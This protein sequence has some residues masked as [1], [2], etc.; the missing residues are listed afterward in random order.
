M[1][2]LPVTLLVLLIDILN[3]AIQVAKCFIGH[4]DRFLPFRYL[5]IVSRYEIENQWRPLFEL[6]DSLARYRI[7][8]LL[9]ASLEKLPR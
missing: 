6:T 8:V 1:N 3:E 4:G 2:L 7:S 9:S 5:I